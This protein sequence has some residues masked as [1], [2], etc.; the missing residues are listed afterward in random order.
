M[1][2]LVEITIR[3]FAGAMDD[4]KE[5]EPVKELNFC[6]PARWSPSLKTWIVDALPDMS[7]PVSNAIRIVAKEAVDAENYRIGNF[8][9][10]PEPDFPSFDHEVKA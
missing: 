10:T 1:D 9:T 3:A 8:F 6:V 2:I 5:D 7:A 4:T